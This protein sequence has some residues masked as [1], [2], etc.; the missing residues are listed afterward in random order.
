MPA[1]SFKYVQKKTH[2]DMKQPTRKKAQSIPLRLDGPVATAN[3][4]ATGRPPARE[5]ATATQQDSLSTDN[6]AVVDA[7]AQVEE[8]KA[9]TF[10]A[11]GVL[12]FAQQISRAQRNTSFIIAT[13]CMPLLGLYAVVGVIA[14]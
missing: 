1:E 10:I 6:D 9:M 11:A 14:W 7:Y 4:V 2:R 3:A 5:R 12:G 13:T 8:L